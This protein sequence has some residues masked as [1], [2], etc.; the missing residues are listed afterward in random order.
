MRRRNIFLPIVELKADK[1]KRERIE[2]L[3][4][5][6]ANGTIFHLQTCPQREILEEELLWYP[7]GKHDDIIDALAYGLQI[8]FPARKRETRH[9]GRDEDGHS[10]R[11]LY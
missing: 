10:R 3:I 11:Y 5:R 2:G 6:Y 1:S 9:Y 8:T 4:P 7:R